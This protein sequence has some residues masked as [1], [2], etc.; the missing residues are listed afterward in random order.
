MMT[1]TTTRTTTTIAPTP[2]HQPAGEVRRVALVVVR[3]SPGGKERVVMHLATELAARGVE[4]VVFCLDNKGSFGEHLEARGISVLALHS[5]R[6]RDIA[7]VWRLARL[8]RRFRPDVINVHD[9]SS[10]PYAF[11][12]NRL[13]V[14]RPIV[15]SCHGLLLKDGRRR[16]RSEC[17][18]MR[19][20][21]AV[22]AV[23]EAAAREYAEALDWS[24]PVSLLP[25]G[26]CPI[27][28][29]D[30]LRHSVR[31]EL[32]LTDDVFAFLA[33]GNVNPEKGYEDL[34]D[35]ARLLGMKS[36]RPFAVL[37]AGG[38]SNH[39]HWQ[40][41]ETRLADLGLRDTVRFLGLREDVE[42]LYSAADAFVLSSR[43]EGLP[44]VL[45][46]AMSAGLPVIAT[47]VGG[48]PS[49]VQPRENGLL[50]PA[51]D[52]T[53]LTDAMAEMM[54]DAA[55]RANL[56]PQAARHVETNH[57]V[58]RMASDYLAVYE[59]STGFTERADVGCR[60]PTVSFPRVLMLG[61]LPPPAGGMATVMDNLRGSA[62]AEK[63]R[64]TVLNNGKTTPEG[65]SPLRGVAAQVKV[66]ARLALCIRRE[67]AEIVHI[68]T[69]SG[70]A[71]W[72]DSLHAAAARAAG[73]RVV[74]HVHGGYFEQFSAHL[75]AVGRRCL[76]RSLG[77]GSATIVLSDEWAKRLHRFAGQTCLRVV[78]NGVPVPSVGSRPTSPVPHFL[79]VGNLGP[80]KGPQDLIAAVGLARQ[81][82]FRGAVSLAGLETEPGQRSLLETR[83]AQCGCDSR[84]RFLGAVSGREKET[85]LANSDCF[86]LPSY[87]EG[88]PMAMLEAMAYGMPVIATRVGAIPE[89]VTDGVEGFLIEPGDVVALADRLVRMERD[90]SLRHRMGQAARKR[91][92]QGYSIETMVERLMAV[93][94]EV[95]TLTRG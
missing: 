9:R 85:V 55:L 51:G 90:P 79:F 10:L 87:A 52:P 21:R 14:R 4:P 92:E 27:V 91:V 5:H 35:A 80:A 39:E 93:Y 54:Q 23:S 16:R 82:D 1:S 33:V 42:A 57:S 49:V 66:L 45:L 37:V 17:I 68:H 50:V 74:W 32:R 58:A 59:A 86:V 12:A 2:P 19:D 36:T 44:M 89:V 61:P 26:V 3:L 84:V 69:C 65:R 67:R 24:G 47:A 60:P 76:R 41:L 30:D 18:A 88:L 29:K 15:V 28:R 38:T 46:E 73:C 94:N 48:V 43:K 40:A 81:S 62:L 20:V 83:I 6:G 77:L 31:H 75:G 22:T 56:G 95:L 71:F 8:L 34:L 7:A 53:A 78:A 64:L 70:F 63:C 13:S 11:L 72:R 25:N